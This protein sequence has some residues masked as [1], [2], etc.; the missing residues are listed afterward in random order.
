MPHQCLKCGRLFEEGSSQL[1]KR[2]PDCGGNRF[3]YTKKPLNKEERN[4]LTDEVGKDI[5]SVLMDLTA[6]GGNKDMVDKSGNWVTIK[7][8]DI[9]KVVKQHLLGKKG[10][11]SEKKEK[12]V[13]HEID[14]FIKRM[15]RLEAQRKRIAERKRTK[16]MRKASYTKEP[17]TTRM[18]R[19]L[20]WRELE[21]E[22]EPAVIEKG[23]IKEQEFIEDIPK[24]VALPAKPEK[25]AVEGPIEFE[26]KER[27]KK[28]SERITAQKEERLHH[29]T[30]KGSQGEGERRGLE[31]QTERVLK[32]KEIERAELGRTGQKK[33]EI[34]KTGA[35]I[36]D[37]KIYTDTRYFVKNF[38]NCYEMRDLWV[39]RPKLYGNTNILFVTAK[40]S[41][42]KEIA[43]IFPVLLRFDGTLEP[44][45]ASS[46]SRMSRNRFAGFLKHYKI[47]EKIEDY[48][49]V[50]RM[51]EWKGKEVKTI[52]YKGR[53]QI[54]I[55][56]SLDRKQI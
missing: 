2:C 33:V 23:E 1:L 46:I 37:V 56:P 11:G 6:G 15:K 26:Q 24:E 9:R 41:E 21:K 52:L 31:S 39:K 3:F 25:K 8:K 54:F 32:Q 50:E 4:V 49:I 47:T 18:K 16:E 35:V 43:E 13:I 17:F 19:I 20:W 42:G 28:Q 38:D 30:F 55:P 48:N 10:T 34:E 29:G 5:K 7:S 14:G 45:A 44:N 51:N 53:N 36:E 22:R 27:E 12:R 40:S